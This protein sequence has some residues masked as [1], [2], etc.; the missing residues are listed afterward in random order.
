MTDERTTTK[1]HQHCTTCV[2]AIKLTAGPSPSGPLDGVNCDSYGVAEL[3]DNFAGEGDYAGYREE[4]KEHGF[5]NIFRLEVIDPEAE[6][7]Y[8]APRPE[9]KPDTDG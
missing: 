3:L 2:H 7:P 4:F 8:H 1:T 5:I 9:P 6:C